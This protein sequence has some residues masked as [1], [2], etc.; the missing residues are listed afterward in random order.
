MCIR[1]RVSFFPGTHGNND[2]NSHSNSR[3][4][5]ILKNPLSEETPHRKVKRRTSPSFM[6]K[7]SWHCLPLCRRCRST[8][9][10]GKTKGRWRWLSKSDSLPYLQNC[11]QLRWINS[12]HQKIRRCFLCRYPK[13]SPGFEV[14][15]IAKNKRHRSISCSSY[16]PDHYKRGGSV[17]GPAELH[18]GR[19]CI[20]GRNS[21]GMDRHP[22]VLSLIH[23]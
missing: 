15:W 3:N 14:S 10:G 13:R 17:H 22:H 4:E 5:G 20:S 8:V 7:Y 1:D 19:N 2:F 16:H 12:R 21:K 11:H 6:P 23:I 9:P 18:R